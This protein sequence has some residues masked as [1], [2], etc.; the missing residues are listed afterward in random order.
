MEKFKSLRYASEMNIFFLKAKRFTFLSH[1]ANV[2]P[3]YQV[4]VPWDMERLVE[5]HECIVKHSQM[6]KEENRL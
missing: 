6:I 5:V 1:L 2:V 4:S 3:L